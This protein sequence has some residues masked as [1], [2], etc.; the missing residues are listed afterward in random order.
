MKAQIAKIVQN[1]NFTQLCIYLL[2]YYFIFEGIN[3]LFDNIGRSERV[4]VKIYN[5][6]VWLHNKWLLPFSGYNFFCRF[7][8]LIMLGY[9]LT[10]LIT[11]AAVAFFD[12]KPIRNAALKILMVAEAM[13]VLVIH[14][15]FFDNNEV[16][17]NEMRWVIWSSLITVCL[18]ISLRF[19]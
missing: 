18:Y 11:G 14:N 10:I 13:E 2:A 7:S 9:G 4:E 1:K 3:N 6:E 19:R 15:P 12:D 5:I 17:K 8:S 16:V